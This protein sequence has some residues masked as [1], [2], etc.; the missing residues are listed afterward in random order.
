M[1]LRLATFLKRIVT[2]A[3]VGSLLIGGTGSAQN[4]VDPFPS[5][6][7]TETTPAE[8]ITLQDA[9][10]RVARSNP[11]RR[12][13]RHLVEAATSRIEQAGLRPNPEIEFGAEDFG[14][15]LPGFDQA[16]FT[17]GLSQEIELWGKR[18]RRRQVAESEKEAASLNMAIADYDLYGETSRRYYHLVHA[19]NGLDLAKTATDL[20]ANIITSVESRLSRGAAMI[21]ELLLSELE[22]QRARLEQTQKAYELASSQNELA[23]L[24]GGS[25]INLVAVEPI[26]DPGAL[27]RLEDLQP[28][29]EKSRHVVRAISQENLLK[30]QMNLQLAENKPNL[31]V[32]GGFKRA[33]AD[34]TNSFIVGLAMPLP[35]F[36]RGQG[37]TKA[38]QAEAMA[39]GAAHQQAL[40]TADAEYRRLARDLKQLSARRKIIHDI[41]LPQAQE[42]YRSLRQSYEKGKVIYSVLLQGEQT[43]LEMRAELNDLDLTLVEQVIVLEQLLGVRLLQIEAK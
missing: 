4:W 31:T 25:E 8:L 2:P 11:T 14:G 10:Q 7:S 32:S 22:L 18:T 12:G 34:R 43:M 6:T 27:K 33:Q 1:K 36:D 15:D 35:F 37:N 30:A 26:M 19:Q 21:S 23:S 42:T 40:I 13:F 9:L 17:A 29:L 24:W 5:P 41:I 28:E 3:I 38:L 16:E 39:A 20:A